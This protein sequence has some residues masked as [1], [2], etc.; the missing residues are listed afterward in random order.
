MNDRIAIVNPDF[1]QEDISVIR[2]IFGV[3]VIKQAIGGFRTVGANNILT[4]KGFIIN[5]RAGDDEKAKLDK[6][7]G[8]ESMRTTANTGSL[9]IGLAAL[10]N[11][12]GLVVG[13]ET[14]GYEL[15]RIMDGLDINE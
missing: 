8:F 14:T 7:L 2:D 3:E 1:K 11:S 12:G 13:E 6:L 4:N 10:A 5:N 9:N 15:A